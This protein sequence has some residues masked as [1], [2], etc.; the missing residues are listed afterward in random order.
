MRQQCFLIL[1]APSCVFVRSTLVVVVVYTQTKGGDFS[2]KGQQTVQKA[3]TLSQVRHQI[4]NVVV[5]YDSV[6]L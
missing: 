6:L 3:S 2:N 5:F 1:I 4:I